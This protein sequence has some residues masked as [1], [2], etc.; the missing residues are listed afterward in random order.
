VRLTHPGFASPPLKIRGGKR[1][2]MISQMGAAR[3]KRIFKAEKDN[4]IFRTPEE[5]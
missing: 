2:V 3:K 1:G 4:E 5:E